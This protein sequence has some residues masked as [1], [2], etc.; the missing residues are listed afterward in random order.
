M[1][2]K[3]KAR[4]ERGNPFPGR[5]APPLGRRALTTRHGDWPYAPEPCAPTSH[6][7]HPS[8][9]AK[10]LAYRRSGRFKCSAGSSATSEVAAQALGGKQ[11][12]YASYQDDL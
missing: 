8:E 10:P 6:A 3:V 2:H 4:L 5:T 9:R 11:V 7:D 1:G 12:V